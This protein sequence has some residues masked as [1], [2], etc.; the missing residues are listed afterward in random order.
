MQHFPLRTGRLDQFVLHD[1]GQVLGRLPGCRIVEDG[2]AKLPTAGQLVLRQRVVVDGDEHRG[3]DDIGGIG[4]L[5]QRRLDIGP[6]GQHHIPALLFKQPG[7]P[8]R[9]I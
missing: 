6:A 1:L 2:R 7:R 8:Q 5:E 9:D 4:P 3:I